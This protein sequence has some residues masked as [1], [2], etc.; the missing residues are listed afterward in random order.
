MNLKQPGF[1]YS[2]S[3]TFTK[4]P[5]RTQKFRETG[6]LKDL[7]RNELGKTCFAHDA[8]YFGNK[9]LAKITFSDK[10]FKD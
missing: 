8:S 7:S 4:Y 1:S 9:D 2:A 6:N 3:G 5:E 10:I